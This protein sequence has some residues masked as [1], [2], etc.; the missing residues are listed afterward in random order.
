VLEGRILGRVADLEG[1]PIADAK[2]SFPGLASNVILTDTAGM[3]TSFRFPEGP[4]TI[5]VE[6]PDGTVVE[7][8]ADVRTGEDAQVDIIADTGAAG[9][10]DPVFDGT[11]VGPDGAGMPVKV[12]IDGMGI[13]ETFDSDETGRIAIALPLGDYKATVSAEGFEAKDIEFSVT[14]EGAVVNETL[15]AANAEP[16]ETPLI[17]GNKY[18]LRVRKG[19]YYSG[20][21]L[22][23]E[24]SAEALDQLAAFLKQHP[25][26]GKVEIRVHTDDRGNPKRRS[27]SRADA[28]VN[29]LVGK[30]IVASRLEANGYGD[31]DPVAVNIT[32]DGR[33]KNNRTEFKVKDYDESKASKAKA[34]AKDK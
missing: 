27:Q 26:Y 14:E 34:K 19:P 1:N 32:A 16:V 12:A 30:G 31:R 4:V 22:N 9:G 28:V 7:Q 8:M 3:F 6:L 10:E 21:D 2:V 13:Q 29:Y 25:E 23:T 18:R 15:A 24:R 5:S 11:F 33:R 17:S 20:D